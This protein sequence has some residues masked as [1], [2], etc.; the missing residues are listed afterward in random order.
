VLEFRGAAKDSKGFKNMSEPVYINIPPS[1][2]VVQLP[3]GTQ[4][5]ADSDSD[6]VPNIFD[7][8]PGTP[9]GYYVF[10]N[11]CRCNDTSSSTYVRGGGIMKTAKPRQPANP[12][13]T[14]ITTPTGG[15]PSI[16]GIYSEDHCASDDPAGKT[17]IEYYCDKNDELKE[18][19]MYCPSGCSDGACTCSD[20]DGGINFFTQ[21]SV[22][23]PFPKAKATGSTGVIN[24]RLSLQL[25]PIKTDQCLSNE[26]LMEYFC[27][28]QGVANTTVRCQYGCG[29]VGGS[30]CRCDD[31]DGGLNFNVGGIAAGRYADYCTD[32]RHLLEYYPVHTNALCTIMHTVH[33]CN[34]LCDNTTAA[35]AAP[36][37]ADGIMNGDET[38]VDCGGPCLPCS[39]CQTGAKYGPSDSPCQHAWPTNEGDTISFNSNDDACNLFDICN[40]DLDYI[41]EDVLDCCVYQGLA[42]PH[43]NIAVTRGGGDLKAC[44]GHY[45]IEGLGGYANWMK[46]YFW[47]EICC[48]NSLNQSCFKHYHNNVNVNKC[49]PKGG[50]NAN[51]QNLLCPNAIPNNNWASDTNMTQNTCKH[52]DLPAHASL[53]ILQT[54]TCT[55]YAIAVVALLRKAGYADDEVYV[56]CDGLHCYN[57]V[58]FPGDAKYHFIDTTENLA[59]PYVQNGLPGPGA[60]QYGYCGNYTNGGNKAC[61]NDATGGTACP[62][63]NDIVGC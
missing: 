52:L 39:T 45:I 38:G 46:R 22:V 19:E 14:G 12:R 13:E 26:T 59:T 23:L 47:P 32:S 60:G 42:D 33:D 40:P 34:A 54:G 6:G 29:F 50:F 8:C 56:L 4:G 27:G 15:W 31:S 48:S 17:L 36:S 49:K 58:K 63:K 53:N 1:P 2:I 51:V 43:C 11:G 28:D 16:E 55:D 62:G 30:I 18:S 7:N 10:S 21:G 9:A 3:P 44:V 20:S 35:C 37:C 25:P 5:L 41:L 24:A 61:K 57:L